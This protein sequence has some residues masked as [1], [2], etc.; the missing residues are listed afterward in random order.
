[1]NKAL[2]TNSMC[3]IS[4]LVAGMC[5]LSAKPAKK[6]PKMPSIPT[7]SI[8]PAPK[9]TRLKTNIYCMTPSLKLLKK[10]R[11]S[12]GNKKTI[13]APMAIVFK[14]NQRRKKSECAS[15]KDPPTTASIKSV[16]VSATIVLPTARLTLSRRERP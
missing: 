16:S 2:P 10:R 11:A 1:M 15:L 3:V 7:N 14:T 5:L 13:V 8:K 4:G 9:K 12:I 6:A